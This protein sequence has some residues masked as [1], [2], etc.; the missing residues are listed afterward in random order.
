MA[1]PS[2][3][4]VTPHMPKVGRVMV[5]NHGTHPPELWAHVAAEQIAPISPDLTGARRRAAMALQTKIVEALEVHHGKVHAD[6]AEKL[7]ADPAHAD[8]EPHSTPYLDA[9]MSD[10]QN[11]A[12]GTDWQ[13]HFTFG[14]TKP[15][16]L[17]AHL[18][19]V[20]E[21]GA[22]HVAP[23]TLDQQKELQSWQRQEL[24][25]GEVARMVRSHQHVERQTHRDHRARGAQQ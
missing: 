23:L 16:W 13:D 6:E 7:A 9:I 10:I 14:R 21:R 19:E 5:T 3:S 8:A 12:A 20:D 4:F 11:A 17:D 22:D 15:T 2:S 1:H 24:V 25:R 18:A